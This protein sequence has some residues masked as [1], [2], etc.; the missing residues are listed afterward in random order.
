VN[1]GFDVDEYIL[2]PQEIDDLGMTDEHASALDE[3]RQDVHGLALQSNRS[4]AAAQL[5][6]GY[7]ELDSANRN[8]SRESGS[9]IVRTT[10]TMP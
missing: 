4:P 7:V 5:V 9:S 3:Q 2:S 8:V 10:L 1:A 6:G